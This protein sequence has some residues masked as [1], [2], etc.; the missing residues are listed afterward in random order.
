[1]HGGQRP[2]VRGLFGLTLQGARDIRVALDQDGDGHGVREVELDE[3]VGLGTIIWLIVNDKSTD[4]LL[5][6]HL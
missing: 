3:S 2:E 1:M 5:A 4:D 6:M